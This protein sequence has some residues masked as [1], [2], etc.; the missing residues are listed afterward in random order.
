[1]HHNYPPEGGPTTNYPTPV[2]IFQPSPD[3]TPPAAVDPLSIHPPYVQP[4]PYPTD[5]R[6][7]V[8]PPPVFEPHPLPRVSLTHP[9]PST[10]HVPPFNPQAAP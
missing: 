1:M 3:P 10:H 8:Y 5:G 4:N 7:A 2:R 6:P 9:V